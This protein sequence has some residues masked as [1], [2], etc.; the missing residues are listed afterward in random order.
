MRLLPAN[1]PILKRAFLDGCLN[2]AAAHRKI[3]AKSKYSENFSASSVAEEMRSLRS[4]LQDKGGELLHERSDKGMLTQ[5]TVK[6][7]GQL[8]ATRMSASRTNT[9]VCSSHT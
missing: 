1:S 6:Q 7:R 9:R 5:Q 3:G 4:G 8:K 2:M